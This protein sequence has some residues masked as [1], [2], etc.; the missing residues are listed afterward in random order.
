MLADVL[1]TLRTLSI[2]KS[3]QFSLHD[4]SAHRSVSEIEKDRIR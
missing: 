2:Y 3:H 1:I 4:F